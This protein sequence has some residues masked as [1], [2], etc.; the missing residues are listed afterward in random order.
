M[1]KKYVKK[2]IEQRSSAFQSDIIDAPNHNTNNDSAVIL[3]YGTNGFKRITALR[4]DNEISSS[5]GFQT[6]REQEIVL[7][8][9]PVSNRMN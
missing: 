5:N 8:Q 3:P 2:I 1:R 4:I 9:L 6:S 7:Y